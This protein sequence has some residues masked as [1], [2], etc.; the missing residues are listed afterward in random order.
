MAGYVFLQ[1]ASALPGDLPLQ[2]LSCPH[3]LNVD[4]VMFELARDQPNNVENDSKLFR[5]SSMP[6]KGTKSDSTPFCCKR[7]LSI[8]RRS[9]VG[10]TRWDFSS[11]FTKH[12]L[13]TSVAN[14]PNY[15]IHPHLHLLHFMSPPELGTGALRNYGTAR[16]VL[17]PSDAL[18]QFCVA[19]VSSGEGTIF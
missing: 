11:S 9:S 17:S 19:A 7:S 15:S 10:A 13:R 4:A 16:K 14:V 8:H 3:C 5:S 18:Y 1:A 2:P 12:S 6:S